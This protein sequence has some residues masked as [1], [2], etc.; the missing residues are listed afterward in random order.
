MQNLTA[1]LEK[2][3]PLW[4]R[5]CRWKDIIKT[6]RRLILYEGVSCIHP[7]QS[8]PVGQWLAVVNLVTNG[9]F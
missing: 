3:K 2:K 4:R 6:E 5:R 8:R 7:V 1:K 9:V